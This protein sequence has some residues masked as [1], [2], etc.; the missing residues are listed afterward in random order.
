MNPEATLFAG[1]ECGTLSPRLVGTA[2]DK[3]QAA[4][5]E[6][7]PSSRRPSQAPLRPLGLSP[8]KG[9]GGFQRIPAAESVAAQP[10]TVAR[11]RARSW[12]LRLQ[13]W[14]EQGAPR[15]PRPSPWRK[16]S[17]SLPVG[18]VA[19]RVPPP[20]PPAPG[21]NAA[22]ASARSSCLAVRTSGTLPAPLPGPTAREAPPVGSALRPRLRAV[23]QA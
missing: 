5:S 4:P 11:F 17:R 8:G 18:G 12:R 2:G 19:A 1:S 7:E 15:W 14:R 22:A 6:A 3:S 9:L 21:L 23:R 13:G 16:G 10:P 20:P